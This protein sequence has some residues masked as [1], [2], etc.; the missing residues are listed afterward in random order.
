MHT[1]HIGVMKYAIISYRGFFMERYSYNLIQ[2]M[3]RLGPSYVYLRPR[4]ND[5]FPDDIFKCIFLNDHV[6]ISMKISL[7][8]VSKVPINNI[9]ALDKI[10]VWHRPDDKPLSEP[11]MVR[12]L[13]HTYVTRPRWVMRACQYYFY[14]YLSLT[15][16]IWK[17][18][19]KLIEPIILW[20]C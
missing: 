10:M 13:M 5:I 20:R 8:F 12:L 2:K 9:P 7:E 18:N 11:M 15:G 19:I 16:N 6:Y 1:N 14:I 17:T 4:Q 3:S